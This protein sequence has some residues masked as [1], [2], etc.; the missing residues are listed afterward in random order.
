MKFKIA[1][2]TFQTAQ[3]GEPKCCVFAMDIPSK[4]G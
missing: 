1:P 4:P 3:R 2:E